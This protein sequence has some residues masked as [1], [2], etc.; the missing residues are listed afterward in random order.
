MLRQFTIFNCLNICTE[1]KCR[2]G[3]DQVWM[4]NDLAWSL[5]QV[6]NWVSTLGMVVLTLIYG[7]AVQNIYRKRRAAA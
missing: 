6:A 4:R 5:P 7:Y 2:S 1:G 3:I